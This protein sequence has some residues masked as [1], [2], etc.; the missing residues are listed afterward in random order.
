[1][2]MLLMAGLGP[3][4]MGTK[5]MEGTLFER[6]GAEKLRE[7]YTELAGAPID[8]NNFRHGGPHGQRVLRPAR[9]VM[10]NLS[11]ATVRSVIEKTGIDYEIFDLE[12]LWSKSRDP[13]HSDYDIVG[14]STTFICDQFTLKTTLRWISERFPNATLI[15]GGQYSNIKFESLMKDYPQI[16]YV[17]RGDAELALPMLIEALMGKG[18]LADIPNLA[19]RLPNGDIKSPPIH[20]IDVNAE[21]SPSFHGSHTTIPYES[22]RGCPFTCKYCSFPAA[23]PKWRYKSADKIRRDW[24]HYV[25]QNN[26]T[27]IKSMDSTF[28][29]P[30]PR[31]KELLATLPGLGV[32][33]EAYSRANVINSAEV[34]DG[35]EASRCRWL[36]VGLESMSDTVLGY[37]DKGVTAAQNERAVDLFSRSNVDLRGSFM[38]GYP[39]ETPEDFE[40]THRFL[41]DRYAGRFFVHTFTL[42]DETMPV[43]QDAELYEIQ[44][45]TGAIWKH[46]GMTSEIAM[47]LRERSLLET[48]WKNDNAVMTLWQNAYERPALPAHTL[49]QNYR[50]EKLFEQL[51]FIPRDLGISAATAARCRTILDDL[52][53]LGVEHFDAQSFH[54][55]APARAMAVGVV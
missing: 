49:R 25:E 50:M 26:A 46:R 33:W 12:D 13:S 28:T 17:V 1:M 19:M 21:P 39:G 53:R 8:L 40:L 23:S 35:L 29:I 37:M 4:V 32:S 43:W 48:R 55:N 11:T 34:I 36:L 47:E 14:L 54:T 44:A 30:P 42:T 9:G 38:V 51:A 52:R 2:K 41:V 7:A 24:A 15:L 20:Y 31:F 6:D 22:M 3:Y 5:T 18:E 10:P 27:M 45:V 16:D